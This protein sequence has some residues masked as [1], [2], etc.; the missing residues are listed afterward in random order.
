MKLEMIECY[1]DVLLSALRDDGTSLVIAEMVKGRHVYPPHDLAHMRLDAARIVACVNACADM[2]D[3]AAEVEQLRAKAAALQLEAEI[4]AQEARTANATIAEIYQLVTGATGEPG[5][6][7]GAEPVRQKLEALQARIAELEAQAA[8]GARAVEVLRK[9]ERCVPGGITGRCPVCKMSKHTDA[10]ELAAIL[11]D[12]ANNQLASNTVPVSR[13]AL[14][15]LR[16]AV[17]DAAHAASPW[18]I[19][20][21]RRLLND[22]DG[23]LLDGGGK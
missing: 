12:A 15:D 6:W 3:P 11:R 18:L 2:D 5:N 7:N 21:A 8:V 23:R 13:E 1:S 19:K 4:H 20:A 10:C 9:V 17:A 16:E 22:A 14:G